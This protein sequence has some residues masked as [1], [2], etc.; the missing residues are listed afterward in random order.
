MKD[1]EL[2]EGAPH[3]HAFQAAESYNELL[4]AIS[5]WWAPKEAEEG[6]CIEC[7]QFR[8]DD[9]GYNCHVYWCSVPLGVDIVQEIESHL[10][11]ERANPFTLPKL[12]GGS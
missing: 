4:A 7:I 12:E 3:C 10:A 8:L 9:D 5:E 2:R 1:Y 11:N 6:T